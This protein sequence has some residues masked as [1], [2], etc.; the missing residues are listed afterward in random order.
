MEEIERCRKDR[1][2]RKKGEEQGVTCASLNFLKSPR[3]LRLEASET[4]AGVVRNVPG[5]EPGDSSKGAL[6]QTSVC[7]LGS[8]NAFQRGSWC[9]LDSSGLDR[10][11]V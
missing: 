5:R 1:G 3:S 11:D 2:A 7:V 8:K 9:A 4:R 10:L 6:M